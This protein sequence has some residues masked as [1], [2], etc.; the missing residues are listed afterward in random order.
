MIIILFILVF[1]TVLIGAIMQGISGIGTGIIVVAIL[2]NFFSVKETTLLVL[3]LLIFGGCTTVAKYHHYI[4]WI[5]IIHFLIYVL[6]G[7]LIAFFVLSSYGELD[8]LRLWLGVFLMLI[9]IYQVFLP[10][11]IGMNDPTKNIGYYLTL[12]LGLSAGILGGVIW[13]GRHSFR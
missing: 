8:A 4:D 10:K 3:V 5:R 11:F 2:P 13:I 7:R 6:F 12:I 1:L 9:L